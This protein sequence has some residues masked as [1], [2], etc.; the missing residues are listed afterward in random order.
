MDLKKRFLLKALTANLIVS[1]S[2]FKNLAWAAEL[3]VDDRTWLY[4]E[5]FGAKGNGLVDDSAALSEC[6][7]VSIL[8]KKNVRFKESAKY[9][10]KETISIVGTIKVNATGATII[11]NGNFLDVIDGAGSEWVG[12]LLKAASKP[13]TITYTQDWSIQ[14]EGT[15]GYG[16]MP[17]DNES[18]RINRDF[19]DQRIGCAL[20]FRSSNG[21]A[22]DG[23]TIKNV[24]TDY[25]NIIIA[26][27]KN[28]IIDSCKI[29]GGAHMGGCAILNGTRDPILWG[30]K[31]RI[32]DF[33]FARG[34][35]HK[36][37]NSIFYQC[38]NNG[39]FLSGSENVVIDNCKFIDNGESGFKTAQ[40]VKRSWT[41]TNCCCKNI[42][43]S[44]CYASGQGYDGFDLQN[45]FGSGEQVHI[46]S[47]ILISNCVSEN[48][49]RTGFISQGGGNFFVDC[50]SSN[51]GSH[52]LVSK[53]SRN[54]KML[55]CKSTNNLQF[56]DGIEL[57]LLGPDCIM[58]ECSVVHNKGKGR[59]FLITH[60]INDPSISRKAGY[61]IR[62]IV[63]DHNKCD[64]DPRVIIIN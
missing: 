20:V 59:Y 47:N 64:I 8:L 4:P 26:G 23:I 32:N 40:Y 53:F 24:T 45:V 18:Q 22:L 51:N 7:K 43:I 54:V 63:Q 16:R 48:N 13:Y 38:R 61:S 15:L 25:G 3:S 49:R 10:C 37:S 6:F 58:E 44:N 62:N 29:K 55:R 12:G 46:P 1:E 19:L 5:D 34:Y 31:N 11:S 56:F 35:G 9:L 52:G 21:Y 36:I 27:F 50:I 28:A 33:E 39:L 30:Y 14:R 17:F 57:G 42:K 60:T 41:N 2:L